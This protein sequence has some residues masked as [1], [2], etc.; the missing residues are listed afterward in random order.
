MCEKK[1]GVNSVTEK[2]LWGND[3]IIISDRFII[4]QNIDTLRT[5]IENNKNAKLLRKDT[6]IYEKIYDLGVY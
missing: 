3:V 5:I 6:A 4:G 1:Y 2:S